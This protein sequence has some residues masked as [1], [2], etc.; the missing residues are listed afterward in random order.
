[1]FAFF[2]VLCLLAIFEDLAK[3]F[4]RRVRRWHLGLA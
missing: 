4:K 2:V 1:M 3:D